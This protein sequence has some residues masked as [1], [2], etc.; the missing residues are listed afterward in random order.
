M[1]PTLL[2]SIRWPAQA[3]SLDT[4]LLPLEERVRRDLARTPEGKE[5]PTATQ[6]TPAEDN[7]VGFLPIISPEMEAAVK[8]WACQQFVEKMMYGEEEETGIP[9]LSID[10]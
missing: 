3:A 10:L 7:L 9:S 5:P 1:T 2:S 4:A 8:H 6:E